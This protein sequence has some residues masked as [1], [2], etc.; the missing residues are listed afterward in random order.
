MPH[1]RFEVIQG[2]GAQTCRHDPDRTGLD[3]MNAFSVLS[4]AP[5]PQRSPAPTTK[6]R[7]CEA[8]AE[9]YDHRALRAVPTPATR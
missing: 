2:L 9:A 7:Y 1:M 4:N 5:Q 8:A 3:L 6:F